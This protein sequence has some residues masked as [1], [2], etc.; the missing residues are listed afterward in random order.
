M[1]RTVGTDFLSSKPW[2]VSINTDRTNKTSSKVDNFENMKGVVKKMS[3]PRP[4]EF[5][6]RNGRKLVNFGARRSFKMPK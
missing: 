6:K 4:F 2:V 1:E 3:L 5:Q